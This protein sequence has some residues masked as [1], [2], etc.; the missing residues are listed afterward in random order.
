MVKYTKEEEVDLLTRSHNYSNLEST[1]KGNENLDPH[2][3]IYIEKPEKET[4]KHIPK[5]VY[6]RDSHNPNS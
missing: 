2:N 6:K 3:C 5:G 1:D 4:M